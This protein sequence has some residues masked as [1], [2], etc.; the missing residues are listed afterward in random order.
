MPRSPF[1]WETH[2]RREVL[3]AELEKLQELPYSLWQDAMKAPMTRAVNGRDGRAYRLLV[4]A[5]WSQ[6]GSED[7]RVLVTLQTPRLHRRL[8]RASFVITPTNR[9]S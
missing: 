7:I 8:M 3:D 2:V 1:V 4:Q 6:R 9:I 5:D